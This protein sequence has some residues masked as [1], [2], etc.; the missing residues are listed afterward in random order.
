MAKPSKLVNTYDQATTTK[1][2]KMA[3]TWRR[4]MLNQM[5]DVSKQFTEQQ[6]KC[7]L[8]HDFLTTI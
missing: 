4:M 2:T 5:S 8:N 7:R 1:M 6:N 3:R